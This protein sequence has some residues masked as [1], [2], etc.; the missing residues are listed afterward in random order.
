LTLKLMEGSL[1][2]T[3]TSIAE[4]NEFKKKLLLQKILLPGDL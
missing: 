4:V 1:K 2:K 3:T